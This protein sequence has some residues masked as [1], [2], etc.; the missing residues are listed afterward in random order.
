MKYL[1]LFLSLFI[2]LSLLLWNVSSTIS[3]GYRERG[4]FEQI[5]LEVEQKRVEVERLKKELAYAQSEEAAEQGA[6]NVLGMSYP[7]EEV[8]FVDE[9]G[10]AG[11]S[12]DNDNRETTDISVGSFPDHLQANINLS[13]WLQL[14]FF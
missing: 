8:V 13:S 12:S 10:L 11:D 7:N 5:S 1:F 2:S 3:K 4:K 9:Q 14:F 6:R